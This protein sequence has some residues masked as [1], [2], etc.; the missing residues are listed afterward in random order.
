M[1]REPSLY[2]KL[3]LLEYHVELSLVANGPES[4]KIKYKGTVYS[5]E[6]ICNL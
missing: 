5:N 2:S 1:Y 3:I 4:V 6:P